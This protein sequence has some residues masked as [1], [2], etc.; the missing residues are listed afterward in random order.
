MPPYVCTDTCVLCA[1]MYCQ[2]A[3]CRCVVCAYRHVCTA[4]MYHCMCSYVSHVF[5]VT[6]AQQLHP[7][8]HSVI[9]SIPWC[10]QHHACTPVDVH[11]AA[12]GCP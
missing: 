8:V 4:C 1:H 11:S 12:H 5:T 3:Q 10:L 7:D 2:R 6:C 9:N